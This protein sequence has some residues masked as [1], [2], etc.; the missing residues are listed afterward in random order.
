MQLTTLK[1][2]NLDFHVK[3]TVPA[4]VV[5]NK[6]Q[7]ELDN[8]AKKANLDGFRVGKAPRS[9]INKRYKD[10]VRADVLQDQVSQ[11]VEDIIKEHGLNVVGQPHLEDLK[12]EETADLEFTLKFELFPVINMPNFK[13]ISIVAPALIV[14]EQE[15]DKQ[16]DELAQTVKAYSKETDKKVKKGDQVTLDAIGY[17]DGVAFDGGNVVNHKLVIGSGT[18]IAGFEDQLIG[19]SKG[20]EVEVNVPFP[21][22]YH[23][24]ELAGKPSKFICQ[25]K[26]VYISETPVIDEEFAKKL[27][28]NTLSELRA[29]IKE[30]IKDQYAESINTIMKMS[31][32]DQ[33]ENVLTFDVPKSLLVQEEKD[34]KVKA[35]Q[36]DEMNDEDSLE[37]DTLFK[38][39]SEEEIKE[40]YH[41][42][43]LRRV[44]V[45][46]LLAE[47]TKIKELK[48]EAVD[49][50]KRIMDQARSFPGEEKILYDFY[51]KNPNAVEYLKGPLLEEK[52]V[53]HIFDNEV[54]IVEQKYTKEQLEEF[55]R[56]QE[57]REI[58]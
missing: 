19:S 13:E 28:H 41:R 18:F 46:L 27:N 47:Y 30:R 56:Q 36:P 38:N 21:E 42:L 20:Q 2:E 35:E 5:N 6:V 54:T 26:A 40:Y 49:L 16:I 25:I 3:V 50:Q 22:S 7:K 8:I 23:V 48:I 37:V 31:L 44:R 24:A 58:I 12:N 51:R 55:I 14:T 33:L 57:D 15:I 45:G 11:S 4:D 39:K 52:T 17:I 32:F 34:L 43:A 29:F 10:S 1:N 9:V 53:K